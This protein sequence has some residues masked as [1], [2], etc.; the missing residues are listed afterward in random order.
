MTRAKPETK[1][2]AA[3]VAALASVGRVAIRIQSG[4]V[5][6]GGG[7]MQLAP[8]GTPDLYVLGWGWLEVKHGQGKPSAAQRKMHALLD[9]NGELVAVVKTPADALRAVVGG[10]R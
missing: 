9:L 10:S 2:Q 3:I 6:V 8:E 4:K 1:A 5:K 7:W